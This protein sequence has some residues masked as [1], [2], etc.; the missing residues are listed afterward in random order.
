MAT[1]RSAAP[2]GRFI[3]LEGGEG[4]GK[5]TQ[6]RALA[7]WLSGQGVEVVVTREPGGSPAAEAIRS[8]L[9][10][11]PVDLWQPMTEALL[12]AAA[13]HEHLTTTVRPAL[14][15]G[16]WVVSDRYVDSSLVYQGVGQALGMDR[17]RALHDL[18]ND[19]MQSDLTLWLDLSVETGLSRA[20]ARG[21]AD[22]Y[23]RF[24]R[25]FHQRLAAGFAAVADA[26]PDRVV[27]IGADAP[28]ADVTTAIIEV[29][30]QRF[31]L[32]AAGPGKGRA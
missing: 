15:A 24:D 1:P 25:D 13:R 26:D 17:V 7:D 11:G 2:R 29:V 28:V 18:A 22:R 30:A 9:V 20:A 19:A 21:G 23:E 12:H 10:D 5:S 31:D 3:T 6:A 14:E 32:P 8:L 27:R 16:Q 4:A